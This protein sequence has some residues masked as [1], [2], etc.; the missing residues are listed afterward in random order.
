M[1]TSWL[2]ELKQLLVNTWVPGTTPFGGWI[3]P[4]PL[5]QNILALVEGFRQQWPIAL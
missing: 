2:S 1:G 5:P 4:T 3:L